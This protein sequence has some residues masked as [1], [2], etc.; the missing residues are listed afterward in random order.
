MEELENLKFTHDYWLVLAPCILMVF[1]ILTGYYN[2]W[3]NK[4]TSSKKMRDGIGKKLAEL[5][6]ILI[7]MI[8]ASAFGINAIKYFISIYIIYM[9]L[10]SI[11]ENCKKLGVPMPEKI[12]E[13]LNNKE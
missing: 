2:S 7:G 13:K 4:K 3:K 11:S 1:D 5:V 9:E 6:Y 12:A 10:V 8:I